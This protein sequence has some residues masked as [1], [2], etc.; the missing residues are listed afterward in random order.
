MSC[1]T[2]RG[3]VVEGGRAAQ[4]RI[5]RALGPVCEHLR[6]EK[7]PPLP[8]D[9]VRAVRALTTSKI[10]FSLLTRTGDLSTANLSE[11]RILLAI[12]LSRTNL[13]VGIITPLLIH[14]GYH[15]A[16]GAPVTAAQEFGA[17]RA[18]YDTCRILIP[19]TKRWPR[20]CDDAAAMVR[21]GEA[22]AVELL[23]RA[24]Y[25]Q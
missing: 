3:I 10:R 16:S 1:A 13:P 11:R 5:E 6:G 21:L 12:A 15:L 23:V 19:D 25:P 14:E 4:D 24:G 9:I 7:K 17:R 2:V 20:G 18:E 8:D 22:R